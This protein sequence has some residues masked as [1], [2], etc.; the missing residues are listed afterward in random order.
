MIEFACWQYNVVISIATLLCVAAMAVHGHNNPALSHNAKVW[1]KHVI[2]AV[3]ICV[4][5]SCLGGYLNEH[6]EP[7]IY[8]TVVTLIEYCIAPF[9]SIFIC[10]AYGMKNVKWAG[11]FMSLN[12]VFQLIA[13]PFG[14]VFQI[15]PDGAYVRGDF[16]IVYLAFVAISA[17]LAI[18]AAIEFSRKF[19]SDDFMTLVVIVALV[20]TGCVAQWINPGLKTAYVCVSLAALLFYIYSDDLI[21]QSLVSESQ[22]QVEKAARTQ[23]R[24]VIGLAEVI[25]ARDENTGHHI[26]RT[27]DYVEV[28]ADAAK[29]AGYCPDILDDGYIDAMLLCAYLHDVGKISI[30]DEILNKPG[31]LSDEEFEI[32]KTH[33]TQGGRIIE[34]IM[35]DVA[36]PEYYEV[37]REIAT[38][39]HE[40]WDG[41][42]YP[43]GLSG[44]S[45]PLCARIM[46]VADVYDALTTQR[47]YKAAMPPEM[48][49]S[50][51]EEGA[52]THFDPELARLFLENEDEIRR[53]SVG[54]S[55]SSRT[56]G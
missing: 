55:H 53:A 29:K 14:L 26:S 19:D 43:A 11:L 13:V 36:D 45:I 31:A 6:P 48:A 54:L 3:S 56:R 22:K 41:T 30:P 35:G 39:H 10:G 23:R 9:I 21:Q 28:L 5:A 2:A 1:F 44:E 42:G 52:G 47:P 7:P 33:T 15:T 17:I 34:A 49:F 24:I 51:I 16:Y 4:I 38:F 27:V 20:A 8:N 46:A 37:G 40:K 12:V 32:I 25:E 50:I 18:V